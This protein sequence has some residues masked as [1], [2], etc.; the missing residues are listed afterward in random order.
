VLPSKVCVLSK[1]SFVLT[2]VLVCEDTNRGEAVLVCVLT[3]HGEQTMAQTKVH[4]AQSA[5]DTNIN[6]APYEKI[7]VS[8]KRIA[9]RIKTL[10]LIP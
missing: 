4:G 8:I 7:K 2:V 1:F 3:N 5:Y 10:I 6:P 9:V